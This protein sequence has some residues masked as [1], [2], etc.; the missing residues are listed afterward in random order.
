M[1]NEIESTR[2]YKPTT[3]VIQL[4]QSDNIEVKSFY[5]LPL[6]ALGKLKKKEHKIISSIEISYKKKYKL[7]LEV[8]DTY[9]QSISYQEALNI[10][11]LVL[12]DKYV[13][14]N[15]DVIWQ[16]SNEKEFYYDTDFKGGADEN[17]R[18]KQMIYETLITL[19]KKEMLHI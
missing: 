13:N 7:K 11:T 4:D 18:L 8:Y 9:T 16:D 1:V 2:Q 6:K 12:Y 5:V 15:G 3:G 17:G 19:E 14:Y 10:I